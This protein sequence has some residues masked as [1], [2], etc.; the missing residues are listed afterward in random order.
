MNMYFR[1]GRSDKDKPRAI[2]MFTYLDIR[3]LKGTTAAGYYLAGAFGAL[4]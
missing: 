1:A 4:A 3:N 2:K